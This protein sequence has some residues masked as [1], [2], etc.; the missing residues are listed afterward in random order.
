M[1]FPVFL[2]TC[3]LYPATLSDLVLRLAEVRVFRPHWSPDVLEELDR[4]LTMVVRPGSDGATRRI[5]HMTDAFPD[6]C[7][8]GYEAF[9]DGMA[10]DPKDRHVL[11]AAVHSDCQVMVTFNIKDF[12]RASVEPHRLTVVDP[13]T[14]LLDQ[15]DLYPRS[16]TRCVREQPTDYRRPSV[17][18]LQLLGILERSG[19]PRFAAEMRRKADLSEWTRGDDD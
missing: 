16:V 12:P 14:F 13:D 11:A 10:C 7:V 1:A 6:A 17:T 3:F 4:N 15:L 8:T 2:D 5:R 18:P 9:I 19:V